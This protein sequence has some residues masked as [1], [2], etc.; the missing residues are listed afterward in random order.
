MGNRGCRE[1]GGTSGLNFETQHDAYIAAQEEYYKALNKQ[2]ET[3][4]AYA[5]AEKE[6][7]TAQNTLDNY[8]SENPNQ[9]MYNI[10]RTASVSD[11]LVALD[12]K[13]GDSSVITNNAY[14]SKD[15]S[16]AENLQNIGA[17][18]G[19]LSDGNYI[20]A[21]SEGNN[22]TTYAGNLSALDSAIGTWGSENT[23]GTYIGK[24]KNYDG[25]V[26]VGTALTALDSAL[27]SNAE[28]TQTFYTI[29]NTAFSDSHT[30]ADDLAALDEV[31]GDKSA[32]SGI[33]KKDETLSQNMINLKNA[34]GSGGSGG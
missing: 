24:S 33:L 19:K 29:G 10:S 7:T 31:I 25:G 13:L 14:I 9:N 6:L 12:K 28:S 17:V 15:D 23:S 3:G 2:T 26:S 27:G 1:K 18:L 11:N 4:K 22:A 16:V 21:Y 8:T 20:K 5:E 30:I 34:I 32:F